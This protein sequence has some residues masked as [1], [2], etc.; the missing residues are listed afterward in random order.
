[1]DDVACMI[2]YRPCPWMKWCWSF[3]TP[4]VC[5]VK[6]GG[7]GRARGSKGLPQG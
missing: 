3:F 5:M 2:G 4:L 7:L 6:A 1:M